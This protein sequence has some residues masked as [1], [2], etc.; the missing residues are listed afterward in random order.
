MN[1]SRLFFKR[2]FGKDTSL[3]LVP[4]T[5]FCLGSWQVH[6]LQW[7]KNLIKNLKEKS[8][9]ILDSLPEIYQEKYDLTR[10]PISGHFVYDVDAIIM[11]PKFLKYKTMEEEFSDEKK[12]IGGHLINAFQTDDGRRIIVNRGWISNENCKQKNH[13]KFINKDK[14]KFIG[15]IRGSQKSVCGTYNNPESNIWTF[16]IISEISKK[17]KTEQMYIEIDEYCETEPIGAQMLTKLRNRH[18]EYV[19]TWYGLAIGTFVYF[20]KN[21]QIQLS[22]LK[23]IYSKFNKKI[24]NVESCIAHFECFIMI[25][26]RNLKLNDENIMLRYTVA[27]LGKCRVSTGKIIDNVEIYC[28]EAV[29]KN[30]RQTNDRGQIVNTTRQADNSSTSEL[31][32]TRRK[33]YL[34]K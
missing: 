21:R 24:Q 25:G 27:K 15:R 7:K 17:L 34:E 19:F 30:R 22:N 10:V 23:T 33:L 3:L 14:V 16:R 26:D 29:R 8:Q 2:Y 11:K 31:S 13:A 12:K 5:F 9:I 20:I 6:R 32:E 18:L 28:S 1:N 4:F